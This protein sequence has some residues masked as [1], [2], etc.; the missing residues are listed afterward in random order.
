MTVARSTKEQM[1]AVR[2]RQDKVESEGVKKAT[3]VDVG[4]KVTLDLDSKDVKTFVEGAPDGE[5]AVKPKKAAKTPKRTKNGRWQL[6]GKKVIITLGLAPEMLEALDKRAKEQ[7][8]SRAQLLEIIIRKEL[9][10]QE[11]QVMFN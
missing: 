2:A 6:K 9:L 5:M 1:A 8:R 11:Q 10:K 7:A 4:Q 3:K